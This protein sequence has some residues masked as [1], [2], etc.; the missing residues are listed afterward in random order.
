MYVLP[1]IIEQ[2]FRYLK[3]ANT[4]NN[5]VYFLNEPASS[6]GRLDTIFCMY[7]QVWNK[8]TC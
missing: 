4:M 3:R 5:D 1:Y 6:S 8:I 2:Y 7:W